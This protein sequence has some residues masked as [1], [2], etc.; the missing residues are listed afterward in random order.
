LDLY[1]VWRQE[2]LIIFKLELL[3][4]IEGD[5]SREVDVPVK[6]G[7]RDVQ[8]T[9]FF[10]VISSSKVNFVGNVLLAIV[11]VSILSVSE[12]LS[13][14]LI[15]GEA[16]QSDSGGNVLRYDVVESIE[17]ISFADELDHNFFRGVHTIDENFPFDVFDTQILS[18][19]C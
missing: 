19:Y 17:R 3:I 2:V 16:N 6:V 13:V 12:G 8:M 9:L 14:L 4:L 10:S 15:F 7:N 5:F 1:T 11:N 18:H